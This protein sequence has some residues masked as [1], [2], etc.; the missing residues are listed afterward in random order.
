MIKDASKAIQHTIASLV[1][2]IIYT[3]M[4]PYQHSECD[5]NHLKDSSR[6]AVYV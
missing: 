2:D 4:H 3:E 5:L 6:M 1:C